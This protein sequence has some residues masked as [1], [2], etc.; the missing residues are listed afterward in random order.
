MVSADFLASDY[1][2]DIELKRALERQDAGE[3]CVIPVIL[4]ACDWK[5]ASFGKLQALP[6]DAKPVNSWSDRDEAFFDVARGIRKAVEELLE[7][8]DTAAQVPRPPRQ[9]GESETPARDVSIWTAIPPEELDDMRITR[10]SSGAATDY[11]YG[12]L[13]IDLYT[14]KPIFNVSAAAWHHQVQVSLLK[15]VPQIGSGQKQQLSLRLEWADGAE[16]PQ[17]VQDSFRRKFLLQRPRDPGPPWAPLYITFE[18]RS[19]QPWAAI[20]YMSVE[21]QQHGHPETQLLY[22][23]NPFGWVKGQNA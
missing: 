15:Q 13:S 14:P 4:R 22:G 18:T 9:K 19:G 1:C 20:S 17:D 8:R 23:P 12:T 2:Y 11:S 7:P 3:A 5:G 16:A 10:A 6:K 21:R